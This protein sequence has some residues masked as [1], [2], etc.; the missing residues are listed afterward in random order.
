MTSD[1]LPSRDIARPALRVAFTLAWL[2][3]ALLVAA[4]VVTVANA[5][6]DPPLAGHPSECSRLD[7]DAARLACYDRHFPRATAGAPPAAPAP[8]V[9]VS[10]AAASTA[11]EREAL[12]G[13]D[14]TVRRNRGERP[15]SADVPQRIESAVT[16]LDALE[17]G[18]QRVTLAN[19][20]VWEQVELASG[21]Q[22]RVGETVSVRQA[23]LNSYLMRARTG[24][25]VRARRLR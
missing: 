12:F 17:P 1:A 14:E 7:A 19:G 2:I 24:G 11:A 4:L 18:R 8:A 16:R 6:G 15:A 20:Q 25:A 5:A 9:P 21:F 23:S 13:L 10:G 22:P 3:G